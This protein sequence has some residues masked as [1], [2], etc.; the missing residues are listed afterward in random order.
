MLSDRGIGIPDDTL[1]PWPHPNRTRHARI[2]AWA[3][4]YAIGDQVAWCEMLG[5]RSTVIIDKKGK[6]QLRLAGTLAAYRAVHGNRNG[7]RRRNSR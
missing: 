6:E 4:E 7:K 1:G 5:D 2:I 3:T